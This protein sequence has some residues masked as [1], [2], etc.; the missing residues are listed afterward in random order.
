VQPNERPYTVN[1]DKGFIVAANGH[2]SSINTTSPAVVFGA[3][4]ARASRIHTM[5]EE[6]IKSKL[7][8]LKKIFLVI[9]LDYDDMITILSDTKDVVA[10][11]AKDDMV[12]ITTRY[13]DE[14]LDRS[15][16]NVI[17]I[18]LILDQILKW[19]S[20][21]D[22]HK[23][24]PTIYMIWVNFFFNNLF[25]G[26]FDDQHEKVSLLGGKIRLTKI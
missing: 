21:F 1:P 8:N 20:R 19:D 7:G 24:E 5:L 13:I 18:K 14:N 26:L 22:K 6:M 10:N 23:T 16:K 9:S 2:L 11:Y 12:D 25:D 3:F 4:I 15:E 17:E